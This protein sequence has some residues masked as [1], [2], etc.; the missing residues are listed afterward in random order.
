MRP[1]LVVRRK[2]RVRVPFLFLLTKYFLMN[3]INRLL[4]LALVLGVCRA[5]ALAQVAV[6]PSADRDPGGSL[7]LEETVRRSLRFNPEIARLDAALADKLG[8]AIETEVKL[9]PTFK[10]TGGRT[11]EREGV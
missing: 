9:N 2:P 10:V 1:S 3:R 11:S 7:S 8:R 5:H 6:A 4:V